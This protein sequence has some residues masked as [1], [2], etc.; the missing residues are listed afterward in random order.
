MIRKPAGKV[1]KPSKTGN[2]K[3]RKGAQS[4]GNFN[5]KTFHK[6]ENI[7]KEGQQ[8]TD[9][10]LIK[11]GTVQ[12]YKVVENQRQVLANLTPGQIF[13]EM[14]VINHEPRMAGAMALEFTELVSIDENTINMTLK[15]S[16]PVINS[17]TKLL[18]QR[19][20]IQAEKL[21]NKEEQGA[22][23]FMATCT[24]LEIMT[25]ASNGDA[26]SYDDLS[27]KMKS[28]TP[29]SQL[30]MDRVIMQLFKINLVTI[31]KA[32]N[33]I[34]SVK[35]NDL[36]NFLNTAAGFYEN[37]N[38]SE[39]A[40][41]EYLDIYDFAKIVKAQPANIYKKIASEEIPENLFFFHQTGLMDWVKEVGEEF[42]QKVKKKRKKIEEIDCVDDVV[43]VDNNTLQQAFSKIGI[44][45]VGFVISKA[46]EDAKKRIMNN[47]G[48]KMRQV[49][50]EEFG[51]DREVDEIEADEAEEE[52]IKTIK[53]IKGVI[54]PDDEGEK[55]EE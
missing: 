55:K 10:Y 38:Q 33:K 5:T 44:N 4:A 2:L 45:A 53:I 9:A 49:I 7:F 37:W 24:L 52:F 22:D 39:E 47:L 14:G 29:A 30:D 25:K 32:K 19:I 27:D 1:R 42:F 13:G 34:N 43:V 48:G 17:L 16:P 35:V 51:E 46:G 40:E 41:L 18:I 36:D 8:A 26:V 6:G 28:M 54:K 15:Q 31:E 23:V 20:R 11:K 12:I 3:K 50:E 21:Y